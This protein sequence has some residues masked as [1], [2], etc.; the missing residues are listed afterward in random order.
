VHTHTHTQVPT[1][2]ALAYH[3][4]TGRVPAPPNQRL[5]YTENF[6]YMLDGAN[7]TNTYRPHPKLVRALVSVCV[8]VF[9]MLCSASNSLC[10]HLGCLYC[11]AYTHPCSACVLS[12]SGKHC[13]FYK[14]HMHTYHVP[15]HFTLSRVLPPGHAH[16]ITYQRTSHSHVSL[17]EHL[18]RTN[19]L[20]T[21]TCPSSW[22]CTC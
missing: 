6:L 12:P 9:V 1:L 7:S 22:P 3:K 2:A 14:A 19:A 18:S 20:H 5:G 15:T 16:A 21:H 10:P 13:F 11:V 4:S 17:Q 8:L